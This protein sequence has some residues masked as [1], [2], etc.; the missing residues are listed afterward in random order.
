LVNFDF[1][2]TR[3]SDPLRAAAT[4]AHEKTESIRPSGRIEREM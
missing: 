1:A 2:R 4:P 3:F